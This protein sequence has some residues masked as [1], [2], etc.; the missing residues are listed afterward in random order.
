[1]KTCS[2]CNCDKQES[3]Y[4]V[5]KASPDGLAYI[6]KACASVKRKATYA[7]RR[8][9]ELAQMREYAVRN[10]EK[11]AEYQ[12]TWAANNKDKC[13]KNAVAWQKRNPEKVKVSKRNVQGRRNAAKVNATPSWSEEL[14]NF[15]AQQANELASMRE[16]TTG[17]KWHVDHEVPLRGAYVCGL[18]VWNN[19][20]VI[21]AIENMRK[22]NRFEVSA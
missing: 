1:M 14:N 3:E 19:L 8:D 7:E 5:R 21:P 11:I 6:C 10:K 4:N 22:S 13:N 12:K 20:R 16:A 17:V 18:H 2:T 15:V 9:V